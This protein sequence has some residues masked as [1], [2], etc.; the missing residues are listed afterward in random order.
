MPTEQ[1]RALSMWQPWAS[2]L[3]A[4]IKGVESRGQN[5]KFRG[6][7]FIHATAGIN[8]KA[9]DYYLKNEDFR[10]YVNE[11]L[12]ISDFKPLEL[13]EFKARFTTGA[14]IGRA[15]LVDS[16]PSFDLKK[17][18]EDAGRWVAWEKEFVLGI[19]ESDRYAWECSGHTTFATPTPIKGCQSILWKIPNEIVI[20]S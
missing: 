20:H 11:F 13:R 10:I 12:Q 15:V 17:I 8:K 5:T 1:R 6:E 3:A 14:I 18:Y 9:Y 19:H 4:G 16:M 7:F 2:L